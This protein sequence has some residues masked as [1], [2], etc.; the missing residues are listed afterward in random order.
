[1]LEANADP[2]ERKDRV[3]LLEVK[4]GR[5]K[6]VASPAFQP[7]EEAGAPARESG[8]RSFS[9]WMILLVGLAAFAVVLA[10]WRLR[11]SPNP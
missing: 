7:V 9:S 1:V 3:R 10:A 5:G 11:P 8:G 2:Y 6:V 4:E